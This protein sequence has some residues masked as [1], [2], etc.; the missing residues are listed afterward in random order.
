M[1]LIEPA[2]IRFE[3][4]AKL[5]GASNVVTGEVMDAGL[6]HDAREAL[7]GIAWEGCNGWNDEI[8]NTLTLS[9]L[10]QLK[11]SGCYDRNIVR[12]YAEMND[13]FHSIFT[14][15]SSAAGSRRPSSLRRPPLVGCSCSR[16]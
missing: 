16:A 2:S 13:R 3:A 15:K 6:N 8:T 10:W 4:W 7:Q 14:W 1:I 11:E 5:V 9:R 12:H